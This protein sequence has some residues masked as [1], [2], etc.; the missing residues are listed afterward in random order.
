MAVLERFCVDNLHQS[1]LIHPSDH[2]PDPSYSP[3]SGC[4]KFT[5][6]SFIL[7]APATQS[8]ILSLSS[9]LC[10]LSLFLISK[11]QSSYH[12]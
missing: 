11:S 4:Q 12:L 5:L 6:C 10:Y 8:T 2:L 1:F 9:S 7:S 3:F